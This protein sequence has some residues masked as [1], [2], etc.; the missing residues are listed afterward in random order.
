MGQP[1]HGE[2]I[3]ESGYVKHAAVQ[4][5]REEIFQGHLVLVNGANPIKKPMP[6]DKLQLLSTYPSIRELS[7]GMLMEKTS[8]QHFISLL[9]A[10][11]GMDDIVAVSGYRTK[12]EQVLIY[13]TS[14]IENGAAYTAC[15]VALPDQSEHQTGLAIDVGKH[16]EDVD[17][18]APSFPDRGIYSSFKQLAAEHGFVQRYKEGKE[19]ITNIS[20]EPWHFRYVGYPHAELMEQN[21]F[22]LEEYID[23]IQNYRYASEHYTFENDHLFVEIYY[24]SAE[25]APTT[26]VPIVKC[27]LYRLS[28]NNRDGFIITAYTGK[29]QKA[30]D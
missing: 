28:G 30:C 9:E 23:F 27:D 18:I 29:G 3:Q 15:Y 24:V 17:F 7:E 26:T 4:V 10:C 12:E 11:Q 2:R 1:K 25:E 13:E 6:L 5:S 21:D 16:G 20:C 14:L 22:C 8:L 19:S